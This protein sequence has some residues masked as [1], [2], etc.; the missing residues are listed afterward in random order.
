MNIEIVIEKTAF[1]GDGLGIM[2]GKTCFVEGALPG[3]KVLAQVLQDKKN[4]IKAKIVKVLKPSP[5]RL[6]PP[7]PY[8]SHCGGCQYQHVDYS[9]ELKFKESEIREIFQ[10]SLKVS[11]ALIEPIVYSPKDYGYRNSITLHRTMDS[12]KEPQRLGFIARDNRSKVVIKNCLIADERF[13]PLYEKKWSLKKNI[14]KIT[15]KLS[16]NGEIFSDHDDTFLRIRAAEKSVLTH[17]KGFFQN[18]LAVTNLL[19]KKIAERIKASGCETFFDLYAGAGTFSLLAATSVPKIYC[20]EENPYSVH[21]LRMNKEEGKLHS[22][23]II[24]GLVEKV[25]RPLFEKEKNSKTLVFF[26]PP[27][28]GLETSAASLFAEETVPDQLIYLSCDPMTQSRDLKI[29]LAKGAYE[30]A[31]V[32]PFDMFPRT[33]HIEVAVHLK[34]KFASVVK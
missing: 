13:R 16:E 31:S 25:F 29:I 30:I 10:R 33:K 15:F 6:T 27:R 20:I 5:H 7:C 28:Q 4:F 18:N 32:N 34:K 2:K 23:E 17:S 19:V 8:V 22:L 1:G 21:A 12:T 11:Q 14:Q 9:E 3:E 24:C 26:D